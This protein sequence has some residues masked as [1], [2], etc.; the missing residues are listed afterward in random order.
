MFRNP[1]HPA[2]REDYIDFAV[3]GYAGWSKDGQIP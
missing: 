2:K 1:K 3:S